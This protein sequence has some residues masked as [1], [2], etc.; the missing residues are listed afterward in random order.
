MIYQ[1]KGGASECYKHQQLNTVELEPVPVLSILEHPR[2][3][4][5]MLALCHDH[6]RAYHGILSLQKH[7]Q[8]TPVI[9][10]V[11]ICYVFPFSHKLSGVN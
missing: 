4:K 6:L 10:A 1:V 11:M 7:R 3:G 2:L 8:G 9:I 5:A